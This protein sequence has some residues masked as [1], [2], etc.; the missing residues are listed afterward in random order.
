MLFQK[1]DKGSGTY[2]HYRLEQEAV[3]LPHG[4]F[5][6]AQTL[7]GLVLCWPPED[8]CGLL[9]PKMSVTANNTDVRI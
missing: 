2:R 8:K 6:L 1:Q 4:H 5:R 7:L 9:V 3:W